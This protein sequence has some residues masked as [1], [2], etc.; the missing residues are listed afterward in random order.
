MDHFGAFA[1]SVADGWSIVRSVAVRSGGEP[2]HSALAGGEAVAPARPATLARL[3]TAGWESLS[4]SVRDAFE[5]FIDQLRSAGISVLSRRDNE[6]AARLEDLLTEADRV[7]EEILAYEMCWPFD[8]YIRRHPG[9]VGDRVRELVER[10]RRIGLEDYARHCDFRDRLRRVLSALRGACD[11]IVTLSA[12]GPAPKGLEGE[13]P[14]PRTY[15]VPASLTGAPAWS[16]PLLRVDGLPLGIQL[17][18]FL[19]GDE[20]LTACARAIDDM[21]WERRVL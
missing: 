8:E 9:L 19:G 1:G 16:L 2:S 12:S 14:G 11:G 21:N 15:A 3:D 4:A 5:A 10:G 13:R 7:S 17:I 20:S 18:G 6:A